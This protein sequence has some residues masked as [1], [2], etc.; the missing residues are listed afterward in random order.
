M[1]DDTARKVANTVM[2]L[3][4]VGV[5]YVIVSRPP[6]RK[7]AWRLALTGLTVTLPAW[8]NQ[9]VRQAWVDSGRQMR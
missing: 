6:L 5:A 3:A 8:L 4:A 9:E 1:T 2:G 7:L